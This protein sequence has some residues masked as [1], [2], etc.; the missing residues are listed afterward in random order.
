MF[1]G[2]LVCNNM[3][4]ILGGLIL[5]VECE[6]LVLSSGLVKM[7]PCLSLRLSNV[8]LSV[9]LKIVLCIRLGC[10]FSMFL[11]L[12]IAFLQFIVVC[13]VLVFQ[14]FIFAVLPMSLR[15]FIHSCFKVKSVG[16][17]GMLLWF[18]NVVMLGWLSQFGSW[19]VVC[20][21]F[22]VE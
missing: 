3:W 19:I 20:I 5:I 9:C 14:A 10:R 18:C 21:A 4:V 7:F 11:Y 8:V 22:L 16:G 2:D 12:L 15:V 17:I 1:R 6:F 13:F